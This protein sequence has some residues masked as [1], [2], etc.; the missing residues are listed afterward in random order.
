[1]TKGQ[2][3]GMTL[4]QGQLFTVKSG[5]TIIDVKISRV[6]G[7]RRDIKVD[8]HVQAPDNF[9]IIPPERQE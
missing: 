4:R 2:G 8:V 1:M 6:R 7:A 5:D 9:L 3:R